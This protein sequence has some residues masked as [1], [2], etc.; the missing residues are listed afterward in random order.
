VCITLQSKIKH[1]SVESRVLLK[2]KSKVKQSHYMP[3]RHLECR[4]YS[5]Y[6][7]LTLALDAVSGQR[8]ALAVLYPQEKDPRYLLD[9]K[10]DGPK[11][12]SGHRG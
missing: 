11:S 10:L 2:S 8:H 7:F 3:W 9:R 5:S 6:S 1:N 12:R 4:K